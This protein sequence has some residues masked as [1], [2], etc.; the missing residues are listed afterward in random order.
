MNLQ[1]IILSEKMS[2]TTGFI[3]ITF[4]EITKSPKCWQVA[5]AKICNINK[6]SQN[7]RTDQWLPHFRWVHRG[8]RRVWLQKGKGR[9]PHGDERFC[10]LTVSIS[11]PQAWYCSIDL[12]DV[13]T[14][15]KLHKVTWDPSVLISIDHFV[16][17]FTTANEPTIISKLKVQCFKKLM[18]T[19]W[20]PKPD[21]N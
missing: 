12:Q 13:T 5:L 21:R 4:F 20:C 19:P 2:H 3:Y 6:K 1:K 9:C 14:G 17:V 11:V 8:R 7:W 16:F 15:G 18:T 10:A